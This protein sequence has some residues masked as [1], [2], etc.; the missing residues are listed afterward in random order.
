MG[1]GCARSCGSI[2]T[3]AWKRIPRSVISSMV[4]DDSGGVD[5]GAQR[6]RQACRRFDAFTCGANDGAPNDH[7]VGDSCNGG[8]LF[9]AGHTKSDAHRQCRFVTKS[10]HGRWQLGREVIAHPRDTK[11]ADEVDETA[12]VRGDLAHAI[13][14]RRWSDESNELERTG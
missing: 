3:S 7:A 9:R 14:W 2:P 11:P 1:C 6:R 12:A 4:C 8:G 13:P 10:L 5:C